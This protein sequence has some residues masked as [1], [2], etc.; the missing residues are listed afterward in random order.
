MKRAGNLK[1]SFIDVRIAAAIPTY[2]SSAPGD[3]NNGGEL[4]RHEWQF[5]TGKGAVSQLSVL[6]TSI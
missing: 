4:V 1:P 6:K 2:L 3:N 5:S